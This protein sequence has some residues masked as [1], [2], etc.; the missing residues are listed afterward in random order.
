MRSARSPRKDAV[1]STTTPR[2]ARNQVPGSDTTEN[3]GQA[4]SKTPTAEVDELKEDLERVTTWLR[5]AADNGMFNNL[6]SR[7]KTEIT[8]DKVEEQ[9]DQARKSLSEGT[10]LSLDNCKHQ[11]STAHGLFSK[12]LYDTSAE[13]RFQNIYAGW[14]WIYL[15]SFL[16][17]IFLSYHFFLQDTSKLQIAF[18]QYSESFIK[19]IYA[20]LWGMVGGIGRALWFLR[21]VVDDRKYRNSFI[22]SILSAPFYGAIFGALAY[23]LMLGGVLVVNGDAKPDVQNVFFLIVVSAVL[24][25]SWPNMIALIQNVADSI[26]TKQKESNA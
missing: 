19:G 9:L 3:A 18:G 10:D 8:F 4:T 23:F 21:D 6:E 25:F 2:V 20:T 5:T 15:I 11:T 26:S 24:G 16:V 17:S 14:G 1:G 13:W 12:A 7:R 22:Q